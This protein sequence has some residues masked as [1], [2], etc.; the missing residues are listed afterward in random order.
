M[1][2]FEVIKRRRSVRKYL[3]T[4]VPDVI[5]EKILDV[6]RIAPS[7]ANKQPWHFILIREESQRVKLKTAYDRSWLLEAPVILIVCVDTQA[8][9]IREDEKEYATVDA[10]IAMQAMI[11]AATNEGLGT[12]W[13]ANFKEEDLKNALAIPKHITPIVMTPIGYPDPEEKMRPFTRKNLDEILH[14]EKW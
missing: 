7:A 13:I 14:R 2:F 9:W 8:G 6:G 11:L 10:A 4:P 5:I 12:C 1:D 3:S